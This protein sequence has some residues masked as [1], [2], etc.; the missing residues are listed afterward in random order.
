MVVCSQSYRLPSFFCLLDYRAIFDGL[1]PLLQDVLRT[2]LTM[3]A[4][5]AGQS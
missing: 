2:E 5:V 1:V 3:D 4:C